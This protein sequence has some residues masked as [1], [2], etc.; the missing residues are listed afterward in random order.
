MKF[1]HKKDSFIV[2]FIKSALKNDITSAA[3]EMAYYLIFAFFPILLVV[4]ASSS[5]ILGAYDPESSFFYSLLPDEIE[6]IVDSYIYQISKNNNLSFL[7]FG[8][9]LTIYTLSRFMRSFKRTVRQIYF[10]SD[11]A[12]TLAETIISIIFSVILIAA[13][14]A[15]LIVIVL[16]DKILF[17]LKG[18]FPGFD[19]PNLESLIHFSFA[20]VLIFS[21]FSLLFFRI[22]NLNQKFKDIYPGAISSTIGLIVI[23]TGF[24]FYMN[25]FSN[26]SLIYGSISAFI[27]LL[28]WIYMSC[29]I[30][31]S[32][33]VINSILYN[34]N[35]NLKG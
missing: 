11:K 15:S 29:L 30:L 22:P 26:Y 24:S 7:I 27:M 4:H 25:H 32:G 8:I 33:S 9:I 12:S 2:L 16:Q 14:Y 21:F 35:H 17:Y 13:F 5:M 23:A 18:L 28:L 31:L 3:A 19:F 1:W 34:K 6:N 10:S 20:A